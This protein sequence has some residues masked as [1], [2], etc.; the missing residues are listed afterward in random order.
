[1]SNRGHREAARLAR[2]FKALSSPKRVELLGLLEHGCCEG[3]TCCTA[4]ELSLCV[5]SLAERLGLAKSTVSHHM[6]ELDTA[7]LIVLAKKGRHNDFSV[8]REVLKRAALFL[9]RLAG[10]QEAA[11]PCCKTEGGDGNGNG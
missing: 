11:S 6:K 10:C 5:D 4:E 2:L 3:N 8:N 7:G 1:M 9:E